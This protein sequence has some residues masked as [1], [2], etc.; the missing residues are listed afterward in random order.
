MARKSQ[1]LKKREKTL[2]SR[3]PILRELISLK[4]YMNTN[5]WK[6]IV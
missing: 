4:S 5:V 3:A 2:N 1:L 6:S